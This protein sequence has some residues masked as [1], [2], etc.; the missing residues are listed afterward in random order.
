[1]RRL[2]RKKRRRQRIMRWLKMRRIL[3]KLKKM[4]WFHPLNSVLG[5][6]WLEGT[7]SI[8]KS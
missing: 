7:L 6:P 4:L 5:K 8:Y 2:A 1:M 3:K